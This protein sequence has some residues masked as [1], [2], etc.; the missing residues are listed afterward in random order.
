MPDLGGE[1]VEQLQVS[2]VHN[3]PLYYETPSGITGVV[4]GGFICFTVFSI[5]RYYIHIHT[6]F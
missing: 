5:K 6:C 1:R 3:F 4:D 2:L